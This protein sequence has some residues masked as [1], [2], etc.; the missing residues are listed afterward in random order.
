M[1]QT[2]ATNLLSNSKML[3]NCPAETP[4]QTHARTVRMPFTDPGWMRVRVLYAY[5][6]THTHT[7][8]ETM[9]SP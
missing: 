9:D 8:I 7:Y 2:K 3:T 1:S 4:E 6:H 5:A